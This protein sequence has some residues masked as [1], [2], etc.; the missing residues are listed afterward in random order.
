MRSFSRLPV[1]ICS[2]RRIV[3]LR[4]EEIDR[5]L[6]QP[7]ADLGDKGLE[8]VEHVLDRPAGIDV[9]AA[10]PKE[11]RVGSYGKIIRSA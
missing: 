8:I 10:G 11:N 2:R 5:H 3:G 6:G 7:A 4:A 1:S 9:I